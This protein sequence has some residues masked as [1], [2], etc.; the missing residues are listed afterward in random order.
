MKQIDFDRA[1]PQTPDCIHAAIEM[2]FRKGQK[3]MKMQNK[4]IMLGSIAAALVIMFA[5]ALATGGL[6]TAPQPDVLAQPPVTD[7]PKVQEEPMVWCTEKGNYYH[8]D[9]HCSGMEGAKRRPLT[10]AQEM[11]K[12]TCPVC[13]PSEYDGQAGKEPI[14]FIYYSEDSQY[15][16]KNQT[17][18]G[19]T[20]PL[21]AE[22][23]NTFFAAADAAVNKSPCP[24][25]L[26]HGITM[27]GD[28]A[29]VNLHKTPEIT[30]AEPDP[31]A[32]LFA[33]AT[34]F[35]TE[36]GSYYH[37]Y[38]DCSGM[39]NASA[40]RLSEAVEMGKETCP[41]CLGPAF[42]FT[43]P[44]GEY[45]HSEKNCSGMEGATA[46]N[47][48][49][50][51][52]WD[53]HPCPTCIIDKKVN[54]ASCD[55]YYHES[56]ACSAAEFY[57][58]KYPLL[59]ALTIGMTPCPECTAVEVTPEEE[60][61]DAFWAEAEADQEERVYAAYGKP[62]Y[63]HKADVCNGQQNN[64]SL[65]LANAEKEQLIPCPDCYAA[66]TSE[67][68]AE[69]AEPV[70]Y[71]TPSGKYYHLEPD[72][73]GMRNAE[74]RT[75]EQVFINSG[76][77]ACP[78]C[79]DTDEEKALLMLPVPQDDTDEVF[80]APSNNYYHRDHGCFYMS[81]VIKADLKTAKDMGHTPCPMCFRDQV[82][83]STF[84]TCWAT[85]NGKYYHSEE[86]C[87]GMQNAVS[88][89]VEE[90][91]SKGKMRCPVCMKTTPEN[92]DLFTTAFGQEIEDL[93][94]GYI[95]EC[96]NYGFEW[97]ISNGTEIIRLC[98]V[99]PQGTAFF[100][101][102]LPGLP[103]LHLHGLT[104]DPEQVHVF[105]KNAPAPIGSMYAEAPAEMEKALRHSKLT[106]EELQLQ[107][108]VVYFDANR[109]VSAC[110]MQ[111][112]FGDHVKLKWQVNADGE[113]ELTEGDFV[114]IQWG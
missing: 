26:P 5:A 113:I 27:I 89:L 39:L 110:E 44:H 77:T 109:Q 75:P 82:D 69:A 40:I 53:K 9:E 100:G 37:S 12:N 18:A 81:M 93:Y 55:M 46:M 32:E 22:A 64:R 16:H 65:T 20:Y 36:G 97:N 6:S 34:V 23:L 67:E 42:V 2:G 88:G 24:V 70:F 83:I 112:G 66:I 8:Y 84:E 96:T 54:V 57:Y 15:F 61:Q 62:L 99:H 10:E 63:Y 29:Y 87:S 33:E 71:C 73:S 41:R 102:E 19:E 14:E 25:C 35:C 72:C 95:Y 107:V 28:G 98:D 45:Y 56:D 51:L 68:N 52:W 50:A 101:E 60:N 7:V 91:R 43:T 1:Y 49:E 48:E 59:D 108:V 103:E 94:P 79:I 90:A 104:A 58:D 85:K 38:A 13:S 74:A 114:D 86:H 47:P 92:Y 3:K 30:P 4:I 106:A 111:F 17:C 21:K 31:K 80:I 11:G 78:S 105:M 76:Y